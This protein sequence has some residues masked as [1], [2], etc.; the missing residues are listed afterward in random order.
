MNNLVIFFIFYPDEIGYWQ[1]WIMLVGNYTCFLED[2]V[3]PIR[4]CIQEGILVFEWCLTES[5][6][7]LCVSFIM[8]L[9]LNLL[10]LCVILNTLK[11]YKLSMTAFFLP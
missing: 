5:I 7:S 2:N 4:K 8:T 11:H 1:L 10:I 3:K 9:I 6:L